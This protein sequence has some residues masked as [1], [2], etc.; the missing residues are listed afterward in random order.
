[1]ARPV[2]FHL[3]GKFAM[4]KRIWTRKLFTR[5]IARSIRS[6]PARA[7]IRL[8]TLEAREVPATFTVLNTNDTGA[9]SLRDAVASANANVG[10][11]TIIFGNGSGGGGT[12]FLD[13]VPDTI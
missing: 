2:S 6:V 12:N 4:I 5:A 7:R 9:G 13:S 10:V 8:E 1:V 3:A 11:D